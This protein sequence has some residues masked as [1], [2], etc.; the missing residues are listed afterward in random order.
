MPDQADPSLTYYNISHNKYFDK[1]FPDP[2]SCIIRHDNRSI[3]QFQGLLDLVDLLGV[4]GGACV[5]L[6]NELIN[7]IGE[8]REVITGLWSDPDLTLGQKAGHLPQSS[9]G[10]DP[11]PSRQMG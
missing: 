4:D 5:P 3:R 11:S 10:Q 8:D 6:Q 1:K 7:E 9:G 2:A